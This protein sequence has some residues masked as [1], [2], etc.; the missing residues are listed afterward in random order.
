MLLHMT[1]YQNPHAIFTCKL[2]TIRDHVNKI[3][4]RI[5]LPFFIMYHLPHLQELSNSFKS[6][7]VMISGIADAFMHFYQAPLDS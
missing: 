4:N 3:S 1:R 2:P 6:L 7:L 5:E